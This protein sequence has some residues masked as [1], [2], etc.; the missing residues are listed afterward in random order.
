MGKVNLISLHLILR[1]LFKDVNGRGGNRVEYDHAIF[2]YP[3]SM[4]NGCDIAPHPSTQFFTFGEHTSVLLPYLKVT[5]EVVLKPESFHDIL[6]GNDKRM[7]Y[8]LQ[9]E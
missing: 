3:L 1:D 5:L 8:H 7:L 9:T 6:R 2:R 4:K